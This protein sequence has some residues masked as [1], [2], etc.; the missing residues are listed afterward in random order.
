MRKRE[1]ILIATPII[2]IGGFML[3]RSRKPSLEI[4]PNIDWAGKIPSVKFGNNTE[5]LNQNTGEI[6]AGITYSERYHLHY[7]TEGNKMI[8]QV[9]NRLGKVFETKTIDFQSKIVY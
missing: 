6:N 8:L 3:Y 1:I 2:I 7:K 9:K 4:L 5:A